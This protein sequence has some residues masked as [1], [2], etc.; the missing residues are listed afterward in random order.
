MRLT[1]ILLSMMLASSIISPA[2]ADNP[3]SSI[4]T[5]EPSQEVRKFE[6]KELSFEIAAN[7]R[8][9]A[10]ESGLMIHSPWSYEVYTCQLNSK[11]GSGEV[12]LGIVVYTLPFNKS[13]KIVEGL[14]TEG[15]SRETVYPSTNAK[16]YLYSTAET[17]KAKVVFIKNNKLVVIEIPMS[18]D[19][20]GNPLAQVA[21][22]YK[23]TVD[24]IMSTVQIK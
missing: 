23:P 5:T 9:L 12:Q 7:F 19:D 18:S 20:N 15:S 13:S 2:V 24:L 4:A 14:N 3:C 8:I 16:M 1:K 10:T 21:D 11:Y 6:N 22:I 17:A